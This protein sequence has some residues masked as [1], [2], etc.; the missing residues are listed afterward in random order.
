MVFVQSLSHFSQKD[1]YNYIRKQCR[2]RLIRIYSA[3]HSAFEWYAYLKIVGVAKGKYG[4]GYY[5]NSGV[6]GLVFIDE[7]YYLTVFL[8]YQYPLNK[9]VMQYKDMH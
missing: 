1:P 9:F 4:K 6:K 3:C 2:S 5:R 8:M 7:P